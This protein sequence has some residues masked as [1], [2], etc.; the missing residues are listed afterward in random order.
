MRTEQVVEELETVARRLG[1]AVRRDR[2]RFRG[3]HCTVEGEP[4]IVLNRLHPAE[5]HLRQLAE[6]LRQAPVESVFLRP[7]TR[8]ALEEAWERAGTVVQEPD[9]ADL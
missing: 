8:K 5:V 7:V 1:I 2:G 9:V 3:G 4:V 6:R